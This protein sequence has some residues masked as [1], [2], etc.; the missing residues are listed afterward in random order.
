[1]SLKDQRQT[2]IYTAKT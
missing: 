2:T 1:M